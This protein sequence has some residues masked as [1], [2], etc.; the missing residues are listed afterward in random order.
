MPDW[1]LS[2]DAGSTTTA[3]Q[4]DLRAE[5]LAEVQATLNVASDCKPLPAA[6]CAIAIRL[7]PRLLC[8]SA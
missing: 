3:P 5:V 8:A 4:R 2:R 6:T 1:G 7:M